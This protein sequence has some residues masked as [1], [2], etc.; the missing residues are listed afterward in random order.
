[1]SR[2]TVESIRKI[3]EVLEAA[4]NDLSNEIHRVYKPD[5]K[6]DYLDYPGPV[7]IPHIVVGPYDKFKIVIRSL[8]ANDFSDDSTV[9]ARSTR[10]RLT[11]VEGTDEE[12]Q[13]AN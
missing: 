12:A 4:E 3:E 2:S 1:M 6:V 9:D 11:K 8:N 5:T 7:W 10:L 13:A